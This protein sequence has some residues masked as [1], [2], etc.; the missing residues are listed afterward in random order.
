MKS[1]RGSR[2]GNRKGIKG[3]RH[4]LVGVVSGMGIK[5]GPTAVQD[6]SLLFLHYIRIH[7]DPY[8]LRRPDLLVNQLLLPL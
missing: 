8:P 3:I 4:R 1:E 2:K 5:R 6:L 7:F